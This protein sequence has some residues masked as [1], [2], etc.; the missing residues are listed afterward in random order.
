MPPVNTKSEKYNEVP[1]GLGERRLG[2]FEVQTTIRR[3]VPKTEGHRN[4][5]TICDIYR[6]VFSYPPKPIWQRCQPSAFSELIN[7]MYL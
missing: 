5:P 1:L 7:E 6:L 4:G 3:M 2:K